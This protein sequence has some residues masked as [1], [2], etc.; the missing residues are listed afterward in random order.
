MPK[1]AS[2]IQTLSTA[3]SDLL[4]E[5]FT[6]SPSQNTK[7]FIYIF[8]KFI[9]LKFVNCVIVTTGRCNLLAIHK[10]KLQSML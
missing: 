4:P 5:M 7:K 2:D 8:L 6:K 1:V 9:S 3:H 10:P